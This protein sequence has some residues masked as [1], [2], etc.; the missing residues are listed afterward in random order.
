MGF[1]LLFNGGFMLIAAGVSYLFKEKIVLEITFSAFSILGIGAIAILLTRK[2]DTKIQKREGY[3]IVALGWFLMTLSGLLPYWITGFIPN[4]S[5]CFFETMSGYTTTGATILADIES[6][7]KSLL[8]WR[9]VTHW[10]GGMGIIV[11]A[12][13]ILPFLG[14]GGFQLLVY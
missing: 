5:S 10:I 1:L 11:L 13:A 12:I 3:L 6:L 9:S 14:I 7:P 2:H 4:F 8:F